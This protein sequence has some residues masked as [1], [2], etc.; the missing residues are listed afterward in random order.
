MSGAWAAGHYR[1]LQQ[2]STAVH[3]L[4]LTP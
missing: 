2:I 3:R 4:T 1:P